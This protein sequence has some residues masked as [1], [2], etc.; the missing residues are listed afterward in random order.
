MELIWHRKHA[1]IK[2][3]CAVRNNART[4]PERESL[5][6]AVMALLVKVNYDMGQRWSVQSILRYSLREVGIPVA[7]PPKQFSNNP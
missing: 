3:K 1:C 2:L 7:N 6:K 5:C 4:R